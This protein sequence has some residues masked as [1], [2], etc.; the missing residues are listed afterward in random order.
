MW[1]ISQKAKNKTEG[2]RLTLLLSPKPKANMKFGNAKIT[3]T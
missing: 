3:K 1:G 2:V